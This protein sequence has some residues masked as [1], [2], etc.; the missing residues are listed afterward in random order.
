MSP[1]SWTQ[2]LNVAKNYNFNALS[3]RK[4]IRSKDE[5]L[6]L[7]WKVDIPAKIFLNI[8]G[9]MSVYP[10]C[11]IENRFSTEWDKLNLWKYFKG[12]KKTP[13][14]VFSISNIMEIVMNSQKTVWIN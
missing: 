2:V 11:S 13:L 5:K 9:L 1:N 12:P 6:A 4:S 3:D 8:R 7:N 10:F 14:C